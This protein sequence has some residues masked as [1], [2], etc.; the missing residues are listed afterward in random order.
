M[1]E[2]AKKKREVEEK[3]YLQVSLLHYRLNNM[4][5]LRE[6]VIKREK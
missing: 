4:V 1:A 3:Q 2:N 5:L 6:S